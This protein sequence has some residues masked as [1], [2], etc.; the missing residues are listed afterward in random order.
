MESFIFV[1]NKIEFQEST[2]KGVKVLATFMELNKPSSNDRIYRIEEGR[3]IAQSLIG[4][5]IKFGANWMGK[6]LKKVPVIGRVLEAW[7]EGNEIRGIVLITAKK[8]IKKIKSWK[9]KLKAKFTGK[10]YTPFL[11]SVGGVADF[12]EKIKSGGK[13]F[14]RLW[15][16]VCTHLQMLPN[17]PKGAGFPTA[18]MHKI[19]EINES[20]MLTNYNLAVCGVD[21]TCRILKCIKDDFEEARLKR[22]EKEIIDEAFRFYFY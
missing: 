3:S 22:L 1:T 10:K 13:I 2:Q 12:A 6:H 18:K 17:D 20:V 14:T 8:F 4:R 11:F 16:A 21:G 19:I 9:S 7:Q 5:P 15:N